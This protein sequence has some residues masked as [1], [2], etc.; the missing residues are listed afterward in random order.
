MG[1][2]MLKG[3]SDLSAVSQLWAQVSPLRRHRLSPNPSVLAVSKPEWALK[4]PRASPWTPAARRAGAGP[5]EYLKEQTRGGQPSRL[6][7]HLP[8]AHSLG[9]RALSSG[10]AADNPLRREKMASPSDSLADW[11]LS[12]GGGGALE[13]LAL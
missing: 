13:Y 6:A 10:N 12:Y 1:K 2:R 5:P 4:G 11:Q 8:A 3:E 9:A 7:Q